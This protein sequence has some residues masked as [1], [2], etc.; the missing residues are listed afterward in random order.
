MSS[1]S[2]PGSLTVHIRVQNLKAASSVGLS[3]VVSPMKVKDLEAT[4]NGVDA[5]AVVIATPIDLNRLIN[6][7]KPSTTVT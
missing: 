2:R 7:E 5:D 1:G 6:I 3:I 4:I